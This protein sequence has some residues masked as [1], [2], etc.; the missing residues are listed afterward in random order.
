VEYQLTSSTWM[1]FEKLRFLL[2]SKKPLAKLAG[3]L[4]FDY[5]RIGYSQ[6][7]WRA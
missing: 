2:G 4:E 7:I 3:S 6:K 5:R 1:N